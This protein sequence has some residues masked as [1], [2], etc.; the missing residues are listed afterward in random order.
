MNH[1]ERVGL[2]DG[3][4]AARKT[5]PGASAEFFEAEAHGL[6]WLRAAGP[7]RVP[8]VLEIGSDFL[9]MEWLES[10][11]PLTDHDERLGLGLAELHRARTEPAGLDRP[12][13]V[14]TL[15]QDNRPCASWCEFY[16]ERRLRPLVLPRWRE[17]FERLFAA[18]P[19]FLPDEPLSRLHG[20][21][22]GGNAL[23]GPLG[24]PCLIDPAVYVGHREIDLAMM[25]LFGGFSPRVWDSY[26]EAYPLTVGFADRVPLYQLY[27]LLVHFHLFGESYATQ[28]EQALKRLPG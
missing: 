8:Q 5:R 11:T 20:D 15:P 7:L 25:R 9:L 1:V 21:L 22:W 10:G 18:L 6:E 3:R 12:N 14:G 16:V 13:Y 2:S 28:V 26:Q 24:E 19:R 4:V 27:P 23:V 17:R